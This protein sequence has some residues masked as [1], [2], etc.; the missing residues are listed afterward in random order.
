MAAQ[1]HLFLGKQNL[2]FRRET[3][4]EGKLSSGRPGSG[5]T[6]DQSVTPSTTPTCSARGLRLDSHWSLLLRWC[7]YGV[8]AVGDRV[9]ALQV[10]RAQPVVV[11]ERDG[12]VSVPAL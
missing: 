9:D 1:K 6:L 10:R 7:K 12:D 4:S 8:E 11:V 2:H 5:T 3:H